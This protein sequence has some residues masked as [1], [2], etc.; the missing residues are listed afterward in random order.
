MAAWVRVWPATVVARICSGAT[1]IALA[2]LMRSGS[3]STR[4][5]FMR[6]PTVPRFIPNTGLVH[7]SSSIRWSVCSMK[8]SPPSATSVSAARASAKRYRRRRRDSAAPATSVPDESRPM[9]RLSRSSG[10]WPP[11]L[12]ASA[13][14]RSLLVNFDKPQDRGFERRGH[15]PVSGRGGSPTFRRQGQPTRPANV[16]PG[17]ASVEWG[18]S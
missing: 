9:P 12:A 14:N 16:L 1:V 7:P 8:P 11:G 3:W 5:S 13:F 17:D 15:C 2:A 18:L 10:F 6:K 4:Q